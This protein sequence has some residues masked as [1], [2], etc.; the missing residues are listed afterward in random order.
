[1]TAMFDDGDMDLDGLGHR[2]RRRKKAQ[3]RRRQA[4]LR[5]V[6]VPRSCAGRPAPTTWAAGVLS[7]CCAASAWTPP[8]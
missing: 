8:A 2:L 5:L 7:R 1:M 3:H 6:A 4:L